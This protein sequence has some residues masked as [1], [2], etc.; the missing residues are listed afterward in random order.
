MSNMFYNIGRE[1]TVFTFNLGNKFDTLKVTDMTNMFN[2]TGRLNSNF[3]INMKNLNFPLAVTRTNM[4]T[5][6]NVGAKIYVKNNTI[7]TNITGAGFTG[8]VIDC[9]SN[10]CP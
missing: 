1:S 4:F 7:G 9:S 5:N 10:S 3:A 6:L 2:A 8:T